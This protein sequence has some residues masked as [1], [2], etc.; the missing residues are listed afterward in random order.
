MRLLALS[1]GALK[2]GWVDVVV[3]VLVLLALARGRRRGAASQ[4]LSYGGFWLGLLVGAAVAPLVVRHFHSLDAKAL[5]A[6]IVVLVGGFVVGG[7]G[8]ALGVRAWRLLRRGHLGPIDSVV[9]MAVAAV[10]TLLACWLAGTILVVG[11]SPTISSGI[12]G[13]RV[14][15]AL[16]NDLPSAPSIFA[17][18]RRFADTSGFPQVFSGIG[19][20]TS[21]PVQVANTPTVRAA[22]AGVGESMVKVVGAGCGGLLEGSGFVVA[23]DLIVT[24]AHVVAGIADP[25]V[26]GRNGGRHAAVAIAFD[27]RYDLAVLRTSGLNEPA[28]RLDRSTVPRGTTGSVLGYPGGGPFTAVPAGV[29]QSLEAEGPDIY[30]RGQTTRQVYAITAVVR[31]GN[32]GGP[33]VTGAGE[34]VGVV[35]SRS[36]ANSHLGY[37]LTSPGV[38]ARVDQ[39]ERHPVPT[40]TGACAAG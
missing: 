28:V 34:V 32:S 2:F 39:A 14:L 24:N 31:P 36:L 11:P 21:G 33:L 17:R 5:S 38:V 19:P 8:G 27:P 29:M 4:L 25:N 9:G 40:S 30:G 22:V 10:A 26:V 7:I 16:D 37:A 15:K 35:F 1:I 13:S 20:P 23:P 3:V 12:E 18:V 6:V